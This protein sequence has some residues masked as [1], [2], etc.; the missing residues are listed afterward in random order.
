[1]TVFRWRPPN[2]GFECRWGRQNRDSRPM[3]SFQ[4]D[5]SWSVITI[6]GRWCSSRL[7]L[8]CLFTTQTVMHQ[9]ILFI[10]A[11]TAWTTKPKRLEHSLIVCIGKSE[12]VRLIIEDCARGTV[13]LKLTTD[14]HDTLCGLSATAGLLVRTILHSKCFM[15]LDIWLTWFSG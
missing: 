10:T 9:R 8:V 11:Q 6:H 3:S 1:M 2:R 5:D 12:A 14:V 13:L 15:V 4:I 7:H